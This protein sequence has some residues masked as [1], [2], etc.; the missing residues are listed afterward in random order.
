[1]ENPLLRGAAETVLLQAVMD[2]ESTTDPTKAAAQFYQLIG[3]RSGLKAL[4]TIGDDRA[5]LD[6]KTVP[7]LAFDQPKR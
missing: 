6:Q 5:V 2:M 1:M 4:L 7:A 3:V